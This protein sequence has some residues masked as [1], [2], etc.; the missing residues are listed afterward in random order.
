MSGADESITIP[1]SV[2][3][4]IEKSIINQ[5]KTQAVNVKIQLDSAAFVNSDGDFDNG[6]IAHEYGHGISI[7][8]S[9][10]TNNSILN[11]ADQMGE[12]WSDWIALIQIKPG[13]FGGD[14]E[15]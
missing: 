3:Q 4:S 15:E 12:G 7:R 2:S 1:I 8:L 5:M 10:G 11:N 14:K 13:D 9:G 6:I